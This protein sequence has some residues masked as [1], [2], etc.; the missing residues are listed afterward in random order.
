[1]T[2]THYDTQQAYYN[3]SSVKYTR[4]LIILAEHLTHVYTSLANSMFQLSTPEVKAVRFSGL[5]HRSIVNI[6]N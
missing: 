1:M 5:R 4:R 3:G 2:P 6:L